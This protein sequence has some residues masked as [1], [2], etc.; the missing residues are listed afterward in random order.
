MKYLKTYEDVLNSSIKKYSVI[1]YKDSK[2]ALFIIEI[3]N[4]HDNGRTLDIILHYRYIKNKN[5]LIDEKSTITRLNNLDQYIVLITSNS[6][7]DC[8][9]YIRTIMDQNKFNL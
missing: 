9:N 1:E 8:L 2:N 6:S 5:K 3:V 4:I 7:E